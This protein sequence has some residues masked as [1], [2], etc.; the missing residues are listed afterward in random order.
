MFFHL[1]GRSVGIAKNV[2]LRWSYGQLQQRVLA[3]KTARIE[4]LRGEQG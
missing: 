4:R 2:W 3:Q 1:S